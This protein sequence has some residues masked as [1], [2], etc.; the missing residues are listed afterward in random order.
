[1]SKEIKLNKLTDFERK[2]IV[3]KYTEAPGSG[4]LLDNKENGTYICKQCNAPLYKS[5][6][7][8]DSQCGWP[9]FDD[10]IAGAVKRIQDADGRRTE[11]VCNNCG[12]HLGH[13]FLNEGYTDKNTRHC[14]NSVSLKF[15]PAKA[16]IEKNKIYFAGGCFWGVEHYFLDLKGVLSTDVGYMGGDLKNPTYEDIC[17]GNTSHIEVLEVVYDPKTIDLTELSKIFFE[18]HDFTQLNR[19]GPDIGYQYR[20]AVFYTNEKQKTEVSSILD[21]LKTKGY[22]VVTDLT[23]AKTFWKAEE[24]HQEYYSKNKST[25]Y[26]HIRKK[27]F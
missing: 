3:E 14:V 1:M 27:I 25:P 17:S 23:N 26:C 8:F 15:Q 12:G 11:I 9:S 16:T 10:E 2:V 22:N 19:Q 5:N 4:T 21:I 7:K 13:V 18:I 24:Y 20:S 6:S